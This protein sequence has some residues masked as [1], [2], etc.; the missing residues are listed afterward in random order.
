MEV[1]RGNVSCSVDPASAEA[2]ADVNTGTG[3]TVETDNVRL[4]L[5]KNRSR[6]EVGGFSCGWTCTDCSVAVSTGKNR[7]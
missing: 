1:V 5:R 6:F 2:K 3:L 7:I 4:R